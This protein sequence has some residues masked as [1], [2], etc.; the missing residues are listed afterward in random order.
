MKR[1]LLGLLLISTPSWAADYYTSAT[2]IVQIR[3]LLN[4]TIAS[5]WTD[6]QLGNWIKEAV[7][8]ISTRALC[9]QASD[10]FL[11]VTSQYEY[12]D[13]VTGGAAGV[14]NIVKL[15]GCF[16]VNPN[17][18]YVGL[19]RI[20]PYQISTLPFMKPGTPKYYYHFA[21]KIGIFPLPTSTENG[22]SVRV[23]YSYQS[24]TIGD[25]PNQYQPLTILYTAA[26]AYKKEHRYAES[27][28]LYKMYL[29]KLNALKQELYN[30]PTEIKK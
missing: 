14:A 8:D 13:L 29:E 23:Y 24:Q 9:L 21:N 17:D 20:E 30:P 7:E 3:S 4:E 27:D 18:E 10:T 11:L 2:A 15:W 26:M 19:K 12:T 22:Q 5:F 6:T 25:L 28:A 16:Y 1:I